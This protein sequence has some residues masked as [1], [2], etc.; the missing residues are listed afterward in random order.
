MFNFNSITIMENNFKFKVVKAH[1]TI[2]KSKVTKSETPSKYGYI[3]KDLNRICVYSH[4]YDNEENP[5][6]IGQGRLSR[7]FNFVNRDIA[8]KTK[9]TDVEKVKVNILYID[10]TIEESINLEKELIA[11][12]GR[13]DN[14]T[15]CLV[16]GNNG[17]TAIGVRAENNYFFGKHLYGEYNGNFGNKYENNPLSI[18]VVQ[19]DILG[20]VVKHWSSAKEANELGNFDAGCIGSCCRKQRHIHKG[21]QWIYEKDYNSNNDYTYI[22]GR[23]NSRIYICLDIY[24]N[25]KKTYYD[26]D[27]LIHDGFNPKLVNQVANGLKKSH[28]NF[29][30]RDFFKLSKED[31]QILINNNLI[32]IRD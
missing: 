4:T 6:Y 31:K 3:T 1:S 12:Y 27:E 9:V 28:A 15:G 21:Y 20:N 10:I 32:E 5:F 11:K 13:I 24:G 17:D 30:F 8:W 26:K 23:T 2:G 22:P 19:I 16:N 25:Y 18:P 7:A 29:V 14:N